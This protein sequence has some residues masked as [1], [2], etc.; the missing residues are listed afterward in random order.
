MVEEEVEEEKEE[1]EKK[2]EKKRKRGGVGIRNEPLVGGSMDGFVKSREK[3]TKQ[4]CT[5]VIR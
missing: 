4:H 2:K 1:K 5:G 3:S